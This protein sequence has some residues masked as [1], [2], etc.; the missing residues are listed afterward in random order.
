MADVVDHAQRLAEAHLARSLA[1]ARVPVVAGVP[2]ICGDCGED[3]ARLV[4]GLCAPCREP[5]P[6]LPRRF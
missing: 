1:A 3:S 4:D 6:R 5:N 2:G